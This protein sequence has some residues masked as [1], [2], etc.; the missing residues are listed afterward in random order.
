MHYIN[1]GF[2]GENIIIDCYQDNDTRLNFNKIK[3]QLLPYILNSNNFNVY[4]NILSK[5]FG[6]T[7][8]KILVD[9]IIV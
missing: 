6:V 9:R 4:Y 1:K 8:D 3:Q 7:K 5:D 2:V